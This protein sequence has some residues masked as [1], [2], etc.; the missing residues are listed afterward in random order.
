MIRAAWGQ[1]LLDAFDAID[2]PRWDGG[3]ARY[4]LRVSSPRYDVLRKIHNADEKIRRKV[5]LTSSGASAFRGG[6]A[7]RNGR[8]PKAAC[9]RRTTF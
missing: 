7:D 2:D 3:D 1:R 5:A 4:P 6:A 9:A 8:R